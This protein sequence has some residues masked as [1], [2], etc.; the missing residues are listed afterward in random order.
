MSITFDT[1]EYVNEL[2]AA[3]VSD[4]Q[5]QAQAK[6]M[7]RVLDAAMAEQ[8]KAVQA[9]SER[10]A[11]ELDSKTERAILKLEM[12]LESELALI[13]KEI[14][15]ARRDTIIWLG[16]M[17]IVGFGLMLRYLPMLIAK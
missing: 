10:T 11:A 3:D 1:L 15:L 4:K 9:A 5:A 2:K 13:R 12:R 6:A 8:A 17:L 14:V 7:R 16:G